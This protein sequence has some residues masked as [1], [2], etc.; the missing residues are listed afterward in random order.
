MGEGTAIPLVAIVGPT[1]S[2]KSELALNIAA[3]LD[4]EIVN[5]DSL[6]VYRYLDIGTAKVLPHERRGIPHHLLDLLN[7]DEVFAAGEYARLARPLLREIAARG[8]LPVVAGGAGFYLSALI[9]GLFPG[10][11]RSDKLRRRLARRERNHPGWLHRLLARYDPPSAGRIHATD[12][13]KLIRAVEVLLETRRPLSSWFAEPRD[14][15]EGFRVL[16][17]GLDPP[18]DALYERLNARCARMF[19][20]GL[21]D[22]VRRVLDMGYPP[23][24]KALQSHGYRQAVQVLEGTL[25]LK[26]ALYIA[27]RDTRRYAKRQWTWFRR[28]QEIRWLRGFGDDPEVLEGALKEVREFLGR[29]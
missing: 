17:I 2:G 29:L 21:L 13:Q 16:K 9:D 3:E 19:E 8:R 20:S 5:C 1:G 4:G 12:V 22:E 10:P 18:R 28:D 24:S 14:A 26:K 25:D 15:L 23:D 6:Q 7:P 27:Q 11:T